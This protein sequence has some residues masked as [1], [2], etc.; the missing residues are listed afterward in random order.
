MIYS[1]DYKV[2]VKKKSSDNVDQ[3]GLSRPAF[4]ILL[5]LADAPKH[6]YAIMQEVEERVGSQYRLWPATLYTAIKRMLA[7]G[8][9]EETRAPNEAAGEDPRRRF[10]RLT[11]RGRVEL[12]R[13]ASRLEA[14]LEIARAKKVLPAG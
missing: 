2:M 5:A 1:A 3:G 8:T 4:H 13:E 9:I 12:A 6:G 14:L 10:Y 7:D 11:R